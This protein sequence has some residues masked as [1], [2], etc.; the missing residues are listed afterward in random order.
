MLVKVAVAVLAANTAVSALPW[1]A[2][3][4]HNLAYRS[5]STTV[6]E[7]AIRTEHVVE[8]LN[9]RK[10]ETHYQG[11]LSFPYGVASGDP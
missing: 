8:R 10:S 5:P 3:V 1:M 7:L 11:N 9:K 6:P 2:S 4:E